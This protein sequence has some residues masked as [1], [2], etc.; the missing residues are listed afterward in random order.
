M[1]AWKAQVVIKPL[2]QPKGGNSAEVPCLHGSRIIAQ[3]VEERII[4]QTVEEA[5]R[6]IHEVTEM[7]V[8]SWIQHGEPLP[9]EVHEV[10]PDSEGK[11]LEP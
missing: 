3:T 10:C 1:R 9:N 5:I 4:A 7:S 6:D 2:L 8:A 11:A